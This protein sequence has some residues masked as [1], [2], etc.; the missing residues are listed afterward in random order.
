MML[1][2]QRERQGRELPAEPGRVL[3]LL[4]P[5]PRGPRARQARRGRPAPGPDQPRCRDRQR[6]GRRCRL[7]DHGS[8]HQRRRGAHGRPLPARQ[9]RP[10][11]RHRDAGGRRRTAPGR[12]TAPESRLR[13]RRCSSAAARS[14]DPLNGRHGAFD[15]LLV[16]GCIAR[17]S[18][19][20]EAARRRSASRRPRV[21]G[22]A[23]PDR[24][25]RAP[26][27]A[28]AGVQGNG[29][30]RHGARRSPAASP[31]SPA[32][33]NTNPVNDSGAVTRYILEK[34]A[35]GGSGARLSDRRACRSASPASSSPRSASCARPASSPSPTTAARSCDG[36][37][38]APRPRVQ[39]ACST[40]R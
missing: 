4:L 1:R 36:G 16:D 24:H 2:M 40:C 11:G 19:A 5:H 23:R 22:R 25:A 31:P 6:R 35:G 3:A 37:A 15:L 21:L 8:G 10:D 26:A 28:G 20:G 29:R 13:C 12:A 27:R 38:H 9:P 18:A 30:H 32:W 7:A 39:R 14:I 17:A 33:P 34:A